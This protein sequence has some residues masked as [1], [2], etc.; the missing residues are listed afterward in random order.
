MAVHPM[1]TG[2]GH[3]REVDHAWTIRPGKGAGGGAAAWVVTVVT[4]V[5][6]A[7]VIDGV[8]SRRGLEQAAKAAARLA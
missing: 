5:V 7:A 6:L 4:V 2:F 3:E 1:L 8:T